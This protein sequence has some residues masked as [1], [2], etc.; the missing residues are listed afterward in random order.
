MGL[1]IGYKMNVLLLP[2]YEINCSIIPK[3]N[4]ENLT[5]LFNISMMRNRSN[6]KNHLIILDSY[7]LI[8]KALEKLDWRVYWYRKKFLKKIDLYHNSPFRLSFLKQAK[9]LTGLPVYIKVISKTEYELS[10][11]DHINKNGEK[12]KVKFVQRGRFGVPFNNTYFH[13][14]LDRSDSVQIDNKS[15]YFFEFVD[16]DNLVRQYQEKLNIY[17]IDVEADI[18]R[19]TV[20]GNKPDRESDFLNELCDNYIKY[21]LQEKNQAS[22]KIIQ[23]IDAQLSGIVDSLQVTSE[24]YTNF[25]SRNKIVNLSQEGSMVVEQLKEIESEESM[26]KIKYEYYKN[27]KNYITNSNKMEQQAIAPSVVGITDPALNNLVSRLS[28]LYSQRNLLSYS[29][30]ETYPGLIALNQEIEQTRKMLDENLKNL[31]KNVE[32]QLKN[33]DD[34]KKKINAQLSRLPQTEQNYINV[35]RQFDINNEL[36]T[37]LLQ[38]RAEAAITKASNVPDIKVLD[39]ARPQSAVQIGPKTIRNA[40]AGLIIGLSIPAIIISLMFHLDSSITTREEVERYVEN[41]IVGEI[42]HNQGKLEIPVRENPRSAITESFRHLRTNLKYLSF[43]EDQKVIAIHSSIPREGKSFVAT[44]LAA[45]IAMSNKKVLLVDGDLRKSSLNN[46]E[47]FKDLDKEKGLSTFLINQDKYK[48][49]IHETGIE[50]LWVCF[51]GIQPPNPA[52][53]LE[54][55]KFDEFIAEAKKQFDVIVIDNAPVFTVTDGTLV[56]VRADINLYVIRLNYSRR[57][58]LKRIRDY[59][60]KGLFN[61]LVYLLNDIKSGEYGSYKYYG[62]KYGYYTNENT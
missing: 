8:K 27:L 7:F 12:K 57:E 60:T 43:G 14:I 3:E 62:D 26:A 4:E 28:E 34:R 2:E 1:L 25:R 19:I 45:I 47:V 13:F 51:S 23:F 46:L 55:K 61:K 22:E 56:G 18:I 33:I 5:D 10:A 15:D 17:L 54:S 53:L 20:R 38:R 59:E 49:I 39:W 50:N 31:I 24:S 29:A 48:D 37:F 44:N 11:N 32:L 30:R 16:I 41:S 21:N 9:N 36:Y 52:E 40:L 6:I 42:V 58:Q 35:K